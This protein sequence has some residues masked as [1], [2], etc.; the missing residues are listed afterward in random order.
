MSTTQ[1]Y[2]YGTDVVEIYKH[3]GEELQDLIKKKEVQYFRH[4]MSPA[5]P[6]LGVNVDW[7]SDKP[8]T[9]ALNDLADWFLRGYTVATSVNRPLYLK[10]QLKKPQAIIDSDLAE[11]AEGAKAEYTAGRYARN[12][13]E[14]RRQM[15]ITIARRAREAAVAAAKVEA[16]HKV[17]E[18]E[19][20]L[21]DLL[22]AY[23]KPAKPKVK[24]ADEVAA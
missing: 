1:Q 6:Q 5:Y 24:K 13:A 15:D 22:N 4:C 16:E 18:E 7:S 11:V 14:M 9:Q 20:A 2:K 23:A 19:F 21:A 3:N 8:L 17:C 10:V 12:V